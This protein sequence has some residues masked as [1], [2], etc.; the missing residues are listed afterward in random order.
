MLRGWRN[1]SCSVHET[2]DPNFLE[3]ALY[4]ISSDDNRQRPSL[5]EHCL[6]YDVRKGAEEESDSG[7]IMKKFAFQ[8]KASNKGSGASRSSDSFSMQLLAAHD[9]AMYAR[10]LR[11]FQEVGN[12]SCRYLGIAEFGQ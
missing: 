7:W 10:W 2:G 11:F 5:P 6:Y 12:P 8:L 1:V 4:T 9:E 3:L